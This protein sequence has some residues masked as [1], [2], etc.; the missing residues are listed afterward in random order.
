M[1]HGIIEGDMVGNIALIVHIFLAFVI[2]V[3]GPLQFLPRLRSK[4][5]KFHKWNGRI[6]IFTA[7]LISAGALFMV[8]NRP[9][10]IGGEFG[11]IATSIN[12]ILIIGFGIM[13]WRTGMKRQFE[14]HRRWAIRTFIVV[15][16]VWFFRI[17]FGTWFLITGFT[18]P[19]VASDLTG[20]FDR[21]LY[22]ASYLVPLVIAEAYIRTKDSTSKRHKK[23]LTIF[24]YAL[25]P[26]LLGGTLITAKFFW[27]S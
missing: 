11:R 19:G 17:G 6:Y 13:A 15:S 25:C 8:F 1:I 26:L 12:G 21:F 14:E 27:L 18:A 2:T 23:L 20:W 9:A 5:S 22:F 24:L 16:G 7:I 10:T 3:C 4:G